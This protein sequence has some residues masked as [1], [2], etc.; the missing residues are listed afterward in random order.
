MTKLEDSGSTL[1]TLQCRAIAYDAS[2][3]IS[4][5]QLKKNST[6]LATATYAYNASGQLTKVT[7][8]ELA[9][10]CRFHLAQSRA[11]NQRRNLS[12]PPFGSES[13]AIPSS[14]RRGRK[15]VNR[16]EPRDRKEWNA[17]GVG[18]KEAHG[19]ASGRR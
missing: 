7:A 14:G 2:S 18:A 12:Y 4:I 13:T 11:W 19:A 10:I 6:V 17:L 9:S 3:R 5:M 16:K 15:K 8:S 1:K